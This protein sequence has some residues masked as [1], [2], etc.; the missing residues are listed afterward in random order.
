MSLTVRI[1][2]LKVK[3]RDGEGVEP[4]VDITD[5]IPVDQ[6]RSLTE[7]IESGRFA[8]SASDINIDGA[9]NH[10]SFIEPDSDYVNVGTLTYIYWDG[11]ELFRG[12]STYNDFSFSD[13]PVR[14]VSWQ[15]YDWIKRLRD[16]S[17]TDWE[18]PTTLSELETEIKRLIGTQVD[19]IPRFEDTVLEFTGF[20][21]FNFNI[22]LG[23]EDSVDG[24]KYHDVW[25]DPKTGKIFSM[26]FNSALGAYG[27]FEIYRLRGRRHELIKNWEIY[28]GVAGVSVRILEYGFIRPICTGSELMAVYFTAEFSTRT[29]REYVR[30]ILIMDPTDTATEGVYWSASSIENLYITGAGTSNIVDAGCSVCSDGQYIYLRK[31]GSDGTIYL[32]KRTQSGAYIGRAEL[33]P[34]PESI[35]DI[36][37]PHLNTVVYH[38]GIRWYWFRWNEMADFAGTIH[39]GDA[40]PE[41]HFVSIYP[42]GYAEDQY[43]GKYYYYYWQDVSAFLVFTPYGACDPALVDTDSIINEWWINDP[44]FIIL[45]AMQ[46]DEVTLESLLIDIAQFFNGFFIHRNGTIYLYNRGSYANTVEV[47]AEYIQN[48]NYERNLKDDS[49]SEPYL[50]L[51]AKGVSDDSENPYNPHTLA[52]AL[53]NYYRTLDQHK[54]IV[55]KVVLPLET[56]KSIRL[57]DRI[58]VRETGEAG[59]VIK[60]RLNLDAAGKMG[61]IEFE[62]SIT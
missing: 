19:G 27:G 29:S 53:R 41:L 46:Y 13:A 5:R 58:R 37:T 42:T 34:Q 54:W 33:T 48:S 61:E 28:I 12:I 30:R 23:D 32:E 55:R 62:R 45:S 21:S 6:V 25:R 20:S 57:G 2:Q 24:F 38:D 11:E 39:T 56:A 60:R 4:M 52:G 50:Q 47:S 49:Q 10:D 16:T 44:M 59:M 9:A 15:S 51:K 36:D 43:N 7:R 3:Y 18:A 14:T 17:I 8:F 26:R 35:S 31:T 40:L 1:Q 22:M